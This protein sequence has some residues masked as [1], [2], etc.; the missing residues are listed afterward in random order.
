MVFGCNSRQP[1]CPERDRGSGGGA[2]AFVVEHHQRLRR[3]VDGVSEG[4]PLVQIRVGIVLVDRK[5][6]CADDAQVS[7]YG[8]R[9]QQGE[10]GEGL[11]Y[12]S[13]SGLGRGSAPAAAAGHTK[14]SE[15]RCRL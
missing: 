4:L 7:R 12:K 11:C 10:A 8:L 9:F 13:T 6:V 15:Q 14:L 3:D 1:P 2:G 5:D